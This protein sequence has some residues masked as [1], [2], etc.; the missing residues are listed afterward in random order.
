MNSVNLVSI[1]LQNGVLDDVSVTI[2]H[3]FKW[4]S[5]LKTGQMNHITRII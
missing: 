1:T 2:K 5:V 3:V 4:D